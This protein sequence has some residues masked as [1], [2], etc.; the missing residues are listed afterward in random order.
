MRNLPDVDERRPLRAVADEM[1]LAGEQRLGPLGRTLVG[2]MREFR[3]GR[4]L[5]LDHGEL[6]GAADP[7][8]GVVVLVGLLLRR[9]DQLFQRLPRRIGAHD[10]ADRVA[11]Q[12][13]DVGEVPYRIPVGRLVVR[14]AQAVDAHAGELVPV[15]PGVQQQGRRQRAGS[16]W[17]RID[18]DRLAEPGAGRLA[19]QPD[20]DVRAAAGGERIVDRD[21]LFRLP[22]GLAPHERRR[23]QH[24]TR[25]EGGEAT[26]PHDHFLRSA[27]TLQGPAPAAA[28]YR[29]TKQ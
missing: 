25:R 8:G 16:A 4:L 2:H 21:R 14:I 11:R 29:N 18:Q 6:A 27:S 1:D 9:V 22:A 24:A 12:A 26:A 7:A 28:R 5:D 3:A 17:P 23:R 10:D 20:M 15:R 19:H 13:D